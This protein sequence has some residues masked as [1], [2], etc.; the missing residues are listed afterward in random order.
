MKPSGIVTVKQPIC[1]NA[2][3]FI[4]LTTTSQLVFGGDYR[5]VSWTDSFIYDDGAFRFVGRGAWPFWQWEDEDSLD[6]TTPEEKFVPAPLDFGAETVDEVIPFELS[7]VA[8][9]LKPAMESQNCNVK[10][11]TDTRIVC[12]R[13]RVSAT[14]KQSGS[15]G[16][17]VTAILERKGDQTHVHIS[18]GKGFAGRLVKQNWSAPIYEQ[19]VKNLRPAQPQ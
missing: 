18:T 9:A 7:K 6:K 19:M 3:F 10:D 14:F 12:K 2:F 1:F 13:P 17:S 4:K 15:G 16:E 11:S 5:A 8:A